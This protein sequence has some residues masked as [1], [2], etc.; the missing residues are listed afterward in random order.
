MNVR[1][2][3]R[4]PGR[5]RLEIVEMQRSPVLA[6][7]IEQ[8]L[9]ALPGVLDVR[10]NTE[11]GRALVR[12]DDRRIQAEAL[13]RVLE[14]MKRGAQTD[15]R[16]AVAATS[17]RQAESSPHILPKNELAQSL[18]T[19]AEKTT[20]A[21]QSLTSRTGLLP[22]TE[23]SD[24][25]S[26]PSAANPY[27]IPLTVSAGLLGLFALK[28][29]FI[30]RSALAS[31][32]G[33]F[34]AAA[35]MSIAAGY[36]ALRRGT[37]QAIKQRRRNPD[38]WLGAA[39]L[40]LAAL[41]EN[42]LA[43]SSITLLNVAM[44]R[45]HERL[46]PCEP[47]MLHPELERHGRTMTRA[48]VWLAPAA[49]LLTGN[50]MAA[51][52]VLLAANPRPAMVSHKHA[53]AQAERHAHD[54]GLPL[55]R[56]G[57]LEALGSAKSIVLADGTTLT[58]HTQDLKV[59]TVRE[60]MNTE[61]T[62][63]LAASLL[64]KLDAHPLR[65]ALLKSAV[66]EKRTHRTAF[67][68]EGHEDGVRG[69]INGHE[70]FFGTKDYIQ[71]LNLPFDLSPFVFQERR[72]RRDGYKPYLLVQDGELL[73]LIGSKQQLNSTWSERVAAWQERGYDVR[74]LQRGE[75]VPCELE[76]MT[77][78]EI[79]AELDS[80][81]PVV[82]FG[83]HDLPTANP[84]LATLS[85]DEIERFDE[86]LQTCAE[87]GE[88][89]ERDLQ[90]VK[91][92]NKVGIGVA[93]L[94][95]RSAP[96]I[97]LLGDFVSVALLSRQFRSR[98]ATATV[99]GKQAHAQTPTNKLLRANPNTDH[100]WH[101]IPAADVLKK[102]NSRDSGLTAAEVRAL[103]DRF[104]V[105]E[106]E[107]PQPPHPL[108]IFFGQFKEFSTVI[109]LGATAVSLLM[110]ERFNAL[111][112]GG[113]LVVNAVIG[114]MQ[115]IRSA[116]VLQALQARDTM[117]TKV[118]RDNSESMISVRDLVPGDIVL[119]EA[120]DSAP[121]DLRVLESWN[122]EV[123]ESILTGESVPAKKR[124][125]ELPLETGLADRTN[126]L[127][128]GTNLTTGRVKAV[129]IATGLATQIG[130]L[131]SL[132]HTEDHAPTPLQQRVDSIG[133][134]FVLGALAAGVVLGIAGWMRGM[135]PL[136]LLLS[137]VTLAASAIPEGLPLTITIALTAGVT[138][139][140]KRKA[141]V[142]K[143]ASLES[144]GRVT[145]ICSDKTGT[146]TRNEMTVKRIATVSQKL[147]VTGEGYDP[148]GRFLPFADAEAAATSETVAETDALSDLPPDVRQMLTIGLLCNNA[149]I[150]REDTDNSSCKAIG[151]PTEAALLTVGLKAGLSKETWTR[152]REIP[153]DSNTGS[154]SVVCQEE[155]NCLLFTK[156]SPE[157]ILGKCTHYLLDG[158]PK[159]LTDEIREQI[160]RDNHEMAE[161]AL[162]VLGFA[163]RE[164]CDD[165]DPHTA[166]DSGLIYVGLMGMID[167]PKADV[168]V[169]IAEAR[170][171]GIK[172]VMITGDH[173]ITAK[174]IGLQLGIYQ[175]GDSILTGA[176]LDQ[177]PPAELKAIVQKTSVFARVSP[178][179][180]LRIVEAYQANGEVVAMT[181]DGVNDAPAVRKADVG[182]AMGEKG[183][184]ITKN[185]AGI[186]LLQD[187][188]QAI[189]EGIKEGRTIIGN[190]RK[191]IG[192]LLTGNLAEVLVTATSVIIG[193]PMPLIPLQVLLMNLLTDALPAMVL[194][195]NSTSSA[196]EGAPRQD[197]VDKSLYRRVLTRG[198]V[199]GIGAL[200]VFAGS[201]STGIALPVAQTMAF[202]TLV[203]GQLIQTVSWRQMGSNRKSTW[204]NDR[205]L[206]AAMGVSWL[207]LGASIYIP[208]L[209][210]IFATAPLHPLHWGVSVAVAGSVSKI[211]N[212][213]LHEK[214]FDSES[215]AFFRCLCVLF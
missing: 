159:E 84:L 194:A 151:D 67:H 77:P 24:S 197:V 174:A 82:I 145:V 106:L 7:R 180:K 81:R 173:P 185:T 104:G 66:H 116:S 131:Q 208:G 150:E 193:L 144:L 70:T 97:N 3:H 142:R 54:N 215:K 181:G 178:E 95:P 86:L 105:N 80:G 137:S 124:A 191:A 126:L 123:N 135:P 102:W 92:W 200:G 141:V 182:I 60:D 211:S 21:I 50:P 90:L 195:T 38:L 134:R 214:A 33:P 183:T 28:R 115:E 93:L 72:L 44:Y 36:P 203:A 8:A 11:T 177:L 204:Q 175:E 108:G 187:H 12:L 59:Q 146:L 138:R 111:C 51:L 37:E 171:L 61:K 31:A 132:L 47:T 65:G 9:R 172:P 62:I 156:G 127:Y 17:E 112:M 103:Q 100:N 209:Q 120:G 89:I 45:R 43:L 48:A 14:R 189:V 155:Q 13:V 52:A 163:Y 101:A 32:P 136:Q 125:G 113:I 149:S 147:T 196:E 198:V 190:I 212:T 23:P 1:I 167:P 29:L 76:M 164:L 168:A 186:V 20:S 170:A 27:R 133:K 85:L 122:L 79:Q 143:L 207:A 118:V 213:L 10:C 49:W 109:L 57:N 74:C 107:A 206:Y 139:M 5:V 96:L 128:M 98:H 55:P 73:A 162:R 99:A 94:A 34:L 161:L 87:A 69:T 179:H 153:F 114:T 25:K 39:A 110:G 169:S 91:A 121:A 15:T 26:S 53:W 199:L 63:S 40:G 201:L 192:C 41:R 119:L 88:Q 176:D 18:S 71:S 202:A 2:A 158:K 140:A 117:Q 83:D 154:M 35:A 148:T 188:F 42:L 130:A 22:A 160:T 78:H 210:R 152:H 58:E 205:L 157:A 184:D 64:E 30:G 46:S 4:L 68:V 19:L 6:Y 165:E 75:R 16:S 56:T 129:V 166:E